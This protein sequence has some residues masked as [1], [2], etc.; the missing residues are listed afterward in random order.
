[1]STSKKKTLTSNCTPDHKPG[2]SISIKQLKYNCLGFLKKLHH[3]GQQQK[4]C[5]KILKYY[6][7]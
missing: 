2:H 1:M 3:S 5:F 4:G 6:I 7:F